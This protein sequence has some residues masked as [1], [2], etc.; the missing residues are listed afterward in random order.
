MNR[1]PTLKLLTDSDLNITAFGRDMLAFLHEPRIFDLLFEDATWT[2]GGCVA[3][4]KALREWMDY[5]SELI[6]WHR[7]GVGDVVD[8]ITVRVKVDG[9]PLYLDGFGVYSEAD[10]A[11]ISDQLYPRASYQITTLDDFALAALQVETLIGVC[12]IAE[13]YRVLSQAF[14]QTFG[15]FHKVVLAPSSQEC[16]IASQLE[17]CELPEPTNTWDGTNKA[18]LKF[19]V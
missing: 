12:W 16:E 4:A 5:D 17:L 8:H 10:L 15:P 18:R 14:E 2:A 11:Y 1:N 7:D 6:A 9:I 3:L 19:Q 13:N